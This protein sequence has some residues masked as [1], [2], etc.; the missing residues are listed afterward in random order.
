MKRKYSILY[1]MGNQCFS[2][3]FSL[4][5]NECAFCQESLSERPFYWT[6]SCGN[7]YHTDCL[8]NYNCYCD[9]DNKK[10]D[11]KKIKKK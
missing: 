1:T 11:K 4:S 6:C 3:Y 7:K 10:K 8:S 5:N 2:S 9:N